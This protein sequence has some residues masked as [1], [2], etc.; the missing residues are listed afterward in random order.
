MSAVATSALIAHEAH[1]LPNAPLAVFASYNASPYAIA[2][3]QASS[4]RTSKDLSG[5]LLAAHPQDAAM[6]LFPKFCK[7]KGL[8]AATVCTVID[9]A[10]HNAMVP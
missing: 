7:K 9:A 1:G 10:P 6:L 5:K 2:V 4:I 8:D 3:P